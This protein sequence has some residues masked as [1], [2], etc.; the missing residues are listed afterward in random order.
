MVRNPPVNVGDTSSMPGLG[1]PT[2]L[3]ATKPVVFNR[4]VVSSS[5]WPCGLQHARLPCPSLSPGVCSNSCPL[6]QWCYLTISSSAALFSFAFNLSQ[7]QGLFKWVDSTSSGQ[8]TG[9][10][11]SASVLPMNIQGGFTLDLTGLTFLHSK[12]LSRAIFLVP[13]FKSINSSMPSLYGPLSHP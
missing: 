8:T 2:Y 9:A 4:S 12:G 11:P 1:R 6:S 7:H 5:F 3:R 10:S 13:Q